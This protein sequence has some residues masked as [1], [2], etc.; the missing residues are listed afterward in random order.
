[1]RVN[2]EAPWD[3]VG[4]G[5]TVGCGEYSGGLTVGVGGGGGGGAAD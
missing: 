2:E 4:S 5:R 3:L 1:M